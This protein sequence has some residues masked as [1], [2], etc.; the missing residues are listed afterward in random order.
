MREC[1]LAVKVKASCA[2][3][4]EATNPPDYPE[5]EPLVLEGIEEASV[6]H[7]VKGPFDI[8]L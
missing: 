2:T 5:G 8:E 3:I 1:R 6:V 7:G 4:E